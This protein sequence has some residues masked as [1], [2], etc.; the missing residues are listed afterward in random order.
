MPR[1]RPSSR[2]RAVVIV[3]PTKVS[4]WDTLRHTMTHEADRAGL[5]VE[6]LETSPGEGTGDLVAEALRRDP[7]LVVAAGGDGT[8]REVSSALAAVDIPLGVVPLGTGNLLARNLGIPLDV[9]DAIAVAFGDTQRAIDLVLL[10]ADDAAPTHFAVM[11]GMGVDAAL[12][13]A[14]N[15]ELKRIMG[16][17]AYL[18]AAPQAVASR[19]FGCTITMEG[20][21]SIETDASMVLIGNVG[22]VFGAIHFMPDAR[23]DDG[24]LDVLIAS[25]KRVTDWA[26]IAGRVISGANDPAEL[27]RVTGHQVTVK[28][29]GGPIEYQLDG[30]SVATCQRMSAEVVPGALTVKVP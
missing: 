17:A 11:S 26:R 14:T 27:V 19:R 25:P 1:R 28:V 9:Q 22:S 2:A 29:S 16:P 15:P 23:P 8:V 30:D 3:N 6:W 10:T 12:M 7:A 24:V 18:L 4:N 5:R 13:N 20:D 21:A